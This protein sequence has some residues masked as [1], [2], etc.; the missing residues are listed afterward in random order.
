MF[1]ELQDKSI[2]Y[3]QNHLVLHASAGRG[4]SNERD[5]NDMRMGMVGGGR[6]FIIMVFAPKIRDMVL[7]V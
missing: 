3:Q 7:S 2:P 1:L 5:I 4:K 6:A